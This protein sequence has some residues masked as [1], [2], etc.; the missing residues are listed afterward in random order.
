MS[1]KN[2]CCPTEHETELDE[3][4]DTSLE[5]LGFE[6]IDQ[7]Y[8]LLYNNDKNKTIGKILKEKSTGYQL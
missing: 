3:K 8:E 5:S 7:F 1:K 2:N 6:S 4:R